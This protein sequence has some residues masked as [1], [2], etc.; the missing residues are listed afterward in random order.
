MFSPSLYTE[1]GFFKTQQGLHVNHTQL[2]SQFSQDMHVAIIGASGGIGRACA[3]QLAAQGNV[4]AICAYSRTQVDL[5]H[6]KINWHSLDVTDED[7]IMQA[8]KHGKA[9]APFD[10]VFITTGF[11]HNAEIFPEKSLKDLNLN[12]FQH[13]FNI[14]TFGPAL[15]AKHFIPL[16]RRDRLSIFA[17]LSARV[18]SI[19]DN[20]LGGWHA[21]RASKAALNMLLKNIAI[22]VGRFHKNICVLGLHPGT[23]NT[24]LSAPFAQGT[25]ADNRFSPEQAA[26]YLLSVINQATPDDSGCTFAWDGQKIPY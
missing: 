21:Y 8:V 7:S 26:T 11:L 15:I 14:N 6:P 5:G 24:E 4:T 16:L 20:R 17:A 18:G 1:N 12:Q 19:S 3:L 22:E 9:F 10:L 25:P 23:V 13:V 2:L